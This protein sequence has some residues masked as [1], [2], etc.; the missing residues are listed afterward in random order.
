MNLKLAATSIGILA[1]SMGSSPAQNTHANVS[2]QEAQDRVATAE[3]NLQNV[4]K[5]ISDRNVFIT[6]REVDV[7][8][9]G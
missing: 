8:K 6:E 4:N 2:L 3:M 1:I 5:G 9:K 7:K